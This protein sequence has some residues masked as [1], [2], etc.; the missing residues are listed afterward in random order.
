M[1]ITKKLMSAILP[2]MLM[3]ILTS[4]AF[5]ADISFAHVSPDLSWI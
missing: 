2:L 1:N 4:P 5:A 3:A